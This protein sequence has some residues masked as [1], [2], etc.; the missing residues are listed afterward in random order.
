[1]WIYGDRSRRADPRELLLSIRDTARRGTAG[2]CDQNDR[3]TRAL[4]EAG[5]LAQGLIDAE[6]QVT[7]EDDLTPLHSAALAVVLAVARMKQAGAEAADDDCAVLTALSNLAG[8]ALPDLIT[9][10]EPEGYAHYAVYPDAYAAAANTGPWPSPPFVIG[11]RSIGASLGA[12]VAAAVGAAGLASLR[13]VGPPFRREIRAS[14]ALRATLSRH[15]GPFIIVDE[16]PGLSGS[17][18]AAAARLLE[19]LGAARDR[20][21]FMPSHAGEPGAQADPDDIARWRAS[22]R[23][24]ASADDRFA[25]HAVGGLFAD[26]IGSP[27]RSDDLSGGRWRDDWPKARRPPAWP[28]QERLKLRLSTSAGVFIVRFAGL[29]RRGAEKM[30]RAKALFAAGFAP[31]PIALRHGLL[32]ERWIGGRSFEAALE[33][34][35]ALIDRLGAYIAFRR[36]TF[37]SRTERGADVE[38]LIRMARVNAAELGGEQL[39]NKVCAR[40]A[41]L[42][43]RNALLR[44]VYIDGRMHP[45]EWVCGHDGRLV[46]TDAIDHAVAHDLIGP[47]DAAWDLAGAIIEFDLSGAEQ[48]RLFDVVRAEAG[49]IVDPAVLS[50]FRIFYLAFQAGWW[51]MAG[52]SGE[53]RDATA[54]SAFYTARL[55]AAYD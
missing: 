29:G 55:A 52:Q 51:A 13:P 14:G 19:G 25:S 34:R 44:P 40:L 20:V 54:R 7:G 30:A 6:F 24:V 21:V 49:L 22:V 43:L 9:C 41:G 31:E 17:S 48:R 15:Q 47:Q 8:M 16:G 27:H 45:G 36:R 32:L 4:I 1:V 12:V 10:S 46:K 50:G 35:T 5:E 33:E 3:L 53:N 11:L 37:P 23:L 38:S 42:D 2:V 18:F 28:A 39:C 26:L